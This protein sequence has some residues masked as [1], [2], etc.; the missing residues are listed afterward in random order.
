[1]TVTAGQLIEQLQKCNPNT[2]VAFAYPD[3][4][5]I[6]DVAFIDD[7]T[8]DEGTVDGIPTIVLEES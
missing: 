6:G 1:M 8:V 5:E 2:R 7:F 3:D 4:A